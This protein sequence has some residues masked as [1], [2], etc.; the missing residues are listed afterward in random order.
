LIGAAVDGDNSTN[1]AL[2]N[3]FIQSAPMNPAEP[4]DDSEKD[5]SV[6]TIVDGLSFEAMREAFD[7][8]DLSDYREFLSQVVA[9]SRRAE[10]G[11][12]TRL[13]SLGPFRDLVEIGRGGMGVVYRA[14][15]PET[16]RDVAVKIPA[17]GLMLTPTMR[18]RFDKEAEVVTRLDHR[19]IV[20]HRRLDAEAGRFY[21]VSEF[22]DGP[23]LE[24]W[25]RARKRPLTAREAARI[26][27]DLADAVAHAHDRDVLHL[28]LKPSNVLLPGSTLA[29]PPE[30]LTP[31]LTDF[32]LAK[33]MDDG[34]S[35][36]QTA[37]ESGLVMGS[38]PYMSPEQAAGRRSQM[39]RPTDVYGLGA[40]LYELLTT[41]PPFRGESAVETLGM[42]MMNDP[43]P[44]RALR[45]RIPRSMEQ[46]VLQ[47]LEKEPELRYPTAEALRDD[48]DAFLAGRRVQA[49][50]QGPVK[51]LR[52]WARRRPR[53]AW[54]AALALA[55]CL[56]LAAGAASWSIAWSRGRDRSEQLAYDSRVQ[57]AQRTYEGGQL[58]RA[59]PLLHG[60][61]PQAGE[62]DRRAFA[63]Y[64]LWRLCRREAR[65][66]F[67]VE[68]GIEHV[69]LSPD[70]SKLA[71]GAPGV[72]ALYDMLRETIDWRAPTPGMFIYAE[73]VFSHDGRR[74]V[75][76]A[77]E[78]E[79]KAGRIRAVEVR[80]A[81]NGALLGR[82]SI[83][84]TTVILAVGLPEDGRLK[85]VVAA[86]SEESGAA[87]LLTWSDRGGLTD[88]SPP[89]RFRAHYAT[90]RDGRRSLFVALDGRLI[91]HDGTTSALTPLGGGPTIGV[92][93]CQFSE[94]GL[95]VA[96]AHG[97][98]AEILVYETRE[99]RLL[100]RL[101]PI[102]SPV[103]EIALQPDGEAVVVRTATEEVRLIDARRGIDVQIFDPR[104]EPGVETKHVRFAPDGSAFFVHRTEYRGP[105]HIEIRSAEDGRRLGETPAR[106]KAPT[107]PW[108]LR[109][110]PTPELIYNLGPF[111]WRWEWKRTIAPG[112]GD[113]LR[114]HNDEVWSVSYSADGTLLA[115]TSNDEREEATIRLRAPD[116]RVVREWRD[117]GSTV[118][119]LAF[120]P[121]GR[122]IATAHLSEERACRMR[123]TWG[124]GEVVSVELPDGEWARSVVADPVRPVVYFGGDRGTVLA[125]DV[126]RR[127]DAWRAMPPPER[128]APKTEERIHGLA[129]APDGRRLAVVNDHGV[130]RSLDARDG[131]VAAS[132]EGRGS[133]LAVAYSPDGEIVA[134][135]DEEGRIHLL[136]AATARSIRVILGDDCDLKALAFSPDGR[137]LAAAGLGRVVR[138]WDASTGEELLSLTGHE[139]QIN[140]MAFS[141]DGE[142]LASADHSGIV[143]FWR[144]PRRAGR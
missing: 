127:Q 67:G 144:A 25:L 35:P 10:E 46:I 52:R 54:L 133:L 45:P 47:C 29:T 31:R 36:I 107:G 138:L 89:A 23:N 104:S 38:P 142:T 83:P 65:M 136:D 105:D 91:V 18:R 130:F 15:D 93:H 42:V 22:C 110:G 4:P 81:S 5:A 7:A 114:A 111:V 19:G 20:P 39:S 16:G 96:V 55:V 37:T 123:P 71:L 80:D 49:R 113:A 58:V 73:P 63:W 137:T 108:A 98:A 77:I 11:G 132:F 21:I 6:P 70:G 78:S 75:L 102:G 125:W 124:D 141:P 34:P 76:L 14:R 1:L 121:D 119:D 9:E 50:R 99:G 74:V 12:A 44:V 2:I 115:T 8:R 140:S 131:R 32:G 143:R 86:T 122:W 57:L 30:S 33:L 101:P 139:A 103:L 40:V 27:R 61:I 51:R 62:R 64:Y 100:R 26:V 48:L 13:D 41:L 3:P 117:G 120:S 28:D 116:G 17:P 60:L 69:A 126:E 90:S 134:A 109:S 79:A 135:G 94:D 88:A 128:R 59:Q 84:A 66:I 92:G 82:R 72:A 85:V 56:A 53:A 129:I 87:D 112:P 95:R 43:V 24:T 106:Y 97:D 118:S 68:A